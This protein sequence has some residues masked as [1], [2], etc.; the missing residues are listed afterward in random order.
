MT[1]PKT[2]QIALLAVE[3]GKPIG[4]TWKDGVR[5]LPDWDYFLVTGQQAAT[6]EW[7]AAIDSAK[8]DALYVFK[9]SCNHTRDAIE[10]MAAVMSTT[11]AGSA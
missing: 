6:T 4:I 3:D 1:T 9:D 11:R 5:H 2:L 7:Q 8:A 10:F